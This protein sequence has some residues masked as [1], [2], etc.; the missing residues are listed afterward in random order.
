ML[1]STAYG[2][3]D[4]ILSAL[5]NTSNE[6]V[7]TNLTLKGIY[8]YEVAD[9]FAYKACKPTVWLYCLTLILPTLIFA[10]GAVI[11]IRRKY[12]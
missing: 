4:V 10:A 11:M 6:T 8:V 7:A 12:R 5:R 1:D 9:A 2:N 3:T